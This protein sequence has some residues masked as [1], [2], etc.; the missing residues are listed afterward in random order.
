VVGPEA[1]GGGGVMRLEEA[2]VGA[3]R[4]LGIGGLHAHA[5]AVEVPVSAEQLKAVRRLCNP[6]SSR[7]TARAFWVPGS[8]RADLG[9]SGACPCPGELAWTPVLEAARC[10]FVEEDRAHLLVG[11]L[12]V[13]EEDAA[14]EQRQDGPGVLVVVRVAA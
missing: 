7:A 8:R 14:A 12:V 10:L 6:M 5:A 1:T 9:L 3:V 11:V 2:I 13:R 4:M